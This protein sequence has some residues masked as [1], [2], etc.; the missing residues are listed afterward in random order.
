M[1]FAAVKLELPLR[2][3]GW[4]RL[5]I[6]QDHFVIQSVI[7]TKA[8][9]LMAQNEWLARQQKAE[10]E[11][12]NLTAVAESTALEDAKQIEKLVH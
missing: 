4:R 12:Q 1:I 8:T 5:M 10:A 11:K 9:L 2:L 6:N 3:P 7:A